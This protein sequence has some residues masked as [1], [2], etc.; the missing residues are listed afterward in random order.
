MAAVTGVPCQ[1]PLLRDISVLILVCAVSMSYLR[2]GVVDYGF[3]YTLLGMYG[4]YVLMVLGAD[5]YHLFYHKPSLL[6]EGGGGTDSDSDGDDDGDEEMIEQLSP[7]LNSDEGREAKVLLVGERTPLVASATNTSYAHSDSAPQQ[8]RHSDPQQQCHHH[9]HT[10]PLYHHNSLPMH[11]HSLRQ[12]FIEAM[13]NYSCK[14]QERQLSVLASEKCSNNKKCGLISSPTAAVSPEPASSAFN[15]ANRRKPRAASGDGWAPVQDDGTEPLVIFH[16]HHAVH[17]HHGPGGLLFLRS[18]STGS[19]PPPPAHDISGADWNRQHSWSHGDD[20]AAGDRGTTDSNKSDRGGGR[21]KESS[22]CD[23]SSSRTAP[24]AAPVSPAT[25]HG[26][27]TAAIL[28]IM[29]SSSGNLSPN[30]VDG[31]ARRSDHSDRPDGWR[32]AWSSNTR[33]FADHWRDFFADIYRNEENGVLDVVL[34]SV[35]LPFTVVRKLTN[36]VPCDGYYCRPLV[37][38]SLALSPLWLWYYF[39]DQFDIDIFASDFG[40]ILS[41]VMLIMGL[42]VMRYAPGGEGPMDF[43]MVVPLTLYG[44][45]IAATWLDSIADK[46]VQFLVLFGILLRIPATVMGLMVLAPGNSLQDLVANVSLSK[47]GLS[48]M[49]TTACLAGPIFNLCVGLGFGFWALMKSTGKGEIHVELPA[50]IATGFYFAIAN[51]ALI[52]FAGRVVGKGMIGRGYGYVA[53]GLYVAYV[54]TSLYV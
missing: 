21:L 14:E 53:C 30:G 28:Q 17:P 39:F 45:A 34:L 4:A 15:K 49:A 27:A 32:E 16:P 5:A 2:G 22:S 7:G 31:P 26:A 35:E 50:N 20:K 6:L 10:H 29:T 51:C 8:Q 37:A 12:N 3:V 41:T 23:A 1:G 42:G 24:F 40:Y 54:V 13:S 52:V 19:S 25:R 33:E 46:L 48:T 47:K 11:S 43:W 18:K 36:P 38:I 44:F 9:H